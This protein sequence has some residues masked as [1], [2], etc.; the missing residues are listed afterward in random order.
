MNKISFKDLT[1]NFDQKI[2]LIE[3]KEVYLTR[4]EY[5]LLQFLLENQNKIFTRKEIIETVWQKKVSFRV[6][7]VTISRLRKKLGAYGKYIQTRNGFG[8][9]FMVE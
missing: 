9:G 4:H 6:V 7:D 2:C 1:L 5:L 8:Y 3:N